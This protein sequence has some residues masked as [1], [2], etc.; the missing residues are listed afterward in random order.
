[1]PLISALWE[2]ET[3]GLLVLAGCQPSSRF[4]G[5]LCL[6]AAKQSDGAGHPRSSSG[7]HMPACGHKYPHRHKHIY[8]YMPAYGHRYPHRQAY[9]QHTHTFS[10]WARDHTDLKP[11]H[12]PLLP[13]STS[14]E[15][16]TGW[17]VLHPFAALCN[18]LG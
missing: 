6:K 12:Q 1:M 9:I 7:F 2:V 16:H 5:Q 14:E 11:Q 4:S 13:L 15:V 17:R 10:M 3:G 18:K 8:I